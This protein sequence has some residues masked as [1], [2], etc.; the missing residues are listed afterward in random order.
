MKNECC[1]RFLSHL[2]LWASLRDYWVKNTSCLLYLNLVL[3]KESE[4]WTSGRKRR[5]QEGCFQLSI[6]LVLTFSKKLD[7]REKRSK[8]CCKLLCC[9][10]Q[11]PTFPSKRDLASDS[12]TQFACGGTGEISRA[13]S[14]TSLSH[15]LRQLLV[16]S[17]AVTGEC[18][19]VSGK[20]FCPLMQI[21]PLPQGSK[22]F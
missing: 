3:E 22:A 10:R 4:I 7:L 12:T 14:G 11:H 15:F 17:T 20:V 1:L 5:Q 6:V 16:H 13:S 21:S 9:T 2:M 18:E 19:L 8:S